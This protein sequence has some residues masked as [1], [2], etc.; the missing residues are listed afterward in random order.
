MYTDFT[1]KNF[2]IFD[3]EGTNVPLRPITI[4]TGCNNTGKSSIV[5]ALCLLKDFCQQLS[6][7]HEN[8]KRL[9]LESYKMDFNKRPNNLLGSF[10][11]V[12]HHDESTD[13]A[14]SADVA[15]TSDADMVSFE[16][17][18]E[19]SWLL[20][21]VIIHLD[22]GTLKEDELNNGYLQAYS[23]K[24]LDGG[25]IYQ[26][27][28]NG[29]A[30][31]DLDIVKKSFLYFIYG[32]YALAN[33]Q[34]A[35]GLSEALDSETAELEA[36]GEIIDEMVKG[37]LDNLSPTALIY[38]FEWQASHCHQPW[39]DGYIG[40]A[41]S[42]L[43]NPERSFVTGSPSL[44]VYCYFP[45]LDVFKDM[46]K[47]DVRKEINKR[48]KAKNQKKT[49]SSSLNIAE[50]NLVKPVS[51]IDQKIIKLF[52]D[53]FDESDAKALHEFVAQ[54]ENEI[55]FD[56]PD[57][58]DFGSNGFA[59][60]SSSLKMPVRSLFQESDLPEKANWFVVIMAMDVINQLMT[61]SSNSYVKYDEINDHQYYYLENDI[62]KYLRCVIEDVFIN[63]LPDSLTYSPISVVELR[64]MFSLEENSDFSETLRT[65][66]ETKKMWYSNKNINP[67]YR[68]AHRDEMRYQPCSFINKWLSQLGIAHHV[69]IKSHAAAS[70]ATIQLFNNEN[71][72]DGMLL[73]DK[74]YGVLQLFAI[75]LKIEIAILKTKINDE[76]YPLE[77]KGFHDNIIKFL[78][79]Y[80]KR[81]PVTIALEEP[82]CHM[83]PSLQ[84]KIAD[85]IVEASREY[86]IHFIIESH[87][88]YFIRKLQL[89]VSQQ[90]INNDDV[91]LLY[92]NPIDRPMYEPVITDIG[93]DSDG[94]LKNEFGRG[95]FDE[96][97]R[98]SKELFN[99]KTENDEEKA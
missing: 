85:M 94:M 96:S 21:D 53:D 39:K 67:S 79:P 45:C 63:L 71:D 93:L 37:I 5:K 32:Q 12:L 11:L 16:L 23:I 13:D 82:E 61:G 78:R 33:W 60:P 27:T 95:F 22:F 73:C 59:F 87:S 74:G 81:H 92:V 65:Y 98:L 44:G 42:L 18:V 57:I 56:D 1:I 48:I 76:L 90:L 46:K 7:D 55:F 51:S 88:E 83:H 89:L 19:S 86:G 62:D 64:R 69:E 30:S 66:F 72:T 58:H 17:I 26:A 31:M 97:L 8:G 29:K 91:S 14:P 24:T 47:S 75:L 43:K 77:T 25:T 4:L 10:D 70:G 2:R 15:E 6:I 36:A 80:V 41:P 52:L 3:R 38:L 40:S 28:R 9:N 54:K 34:G 68:I 50:E 20:Q 35:I 49:K 84:S 99:P